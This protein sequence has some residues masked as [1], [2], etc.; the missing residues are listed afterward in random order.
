MTVGSGQMPEPRP[1]PC[2]F[3]GSEDIG[4]RGHTGLGK[5]ADE[6]FWSLTCED[7]HASVETRM[8]RKALVE[9]WNRRPAGRP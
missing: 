7:C 5:H 8:D 9:A 6:V 4:I 1:G 3:C 2:P